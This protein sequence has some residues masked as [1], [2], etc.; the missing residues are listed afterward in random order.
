MAPF[1]VAISCGAWL[2]FQWRKTNIAAAIYCRLVIF[3]G[4]FNVAVYFLHA[5]PKESSGS[6]A[7]RKMRKYEFVAENGVHVWLKQ[8]ERED[9]AEM[10]QVLKT[11]TKPSDYIVCYPYA[12]TIN[13][14][15]NRPS[16]EYNLYVDNAH[17]VS[18]FFQ[19]TLAEVAKYRPAAILIDN[20]A[21]NQTEESR[22]CN[23]APETYDWIKSN[24]AYAGTF[25]RQEI[26]LRPDLYHERNQ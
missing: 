11:H 12:P 19:E 7:A 24:Y 14:M 26:Y 4:L 8:K 9:I 6:I 10:F 1:V 20:R 18:D 23:W 17:N 15:T 21:L 13:F 3:L 22:F 25:R 2:A 16:Y 5:F